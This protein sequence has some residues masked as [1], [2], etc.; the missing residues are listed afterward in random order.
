MGKLLH[1][2]AVKVAKSNKDLDVSEGLGLRPVAD[3]FHA[4]R[5][6]FEAVPGHDEP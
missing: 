5:V 6:H 3:S 4:F 2:L 1:E